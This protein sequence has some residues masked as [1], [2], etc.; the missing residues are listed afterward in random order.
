MSTGSYIITDL[1]RILERGRIACD[2]YI[3]GALALYL[4]IV[5]MF[6]YLLRLFGRLKKK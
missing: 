1:F 2:D 3:M 4:D 5:R 6:M